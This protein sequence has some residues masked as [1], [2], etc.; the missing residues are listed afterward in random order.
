MARLRQIKP[1]YGLAAA[2]EELGHHANQSFVGE[3]LAGLARAGL[4]A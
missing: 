1:D 4:A 2:A 3:Y